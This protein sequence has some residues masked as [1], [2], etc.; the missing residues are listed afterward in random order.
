MAKAYTQNEFDMLMEKVEKVDIRVKNYLE[1][2]G[3]DK[4][5]RIY[6]PVNRAWT[7][8][9]NIAESINSS[10]VEVIPSTE[11]VHTVIDQGWR[12]IVCIEKKNCSCKEFQ[13]EEIPC[14]SA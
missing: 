5:A 11:Y 2:A 7:M 6:A 14:P 9:S 4:W 1:E 13:M 8:T 3:R 10:F 12:F